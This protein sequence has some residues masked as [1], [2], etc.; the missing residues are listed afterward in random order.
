[1]AINCPHCKAPIDLANVSMDEV[2][3]PACGSNFRVTTGLTTASMPRD[4]EKSIGR[5]QLL[6]PLGM[7]AFGTV[8]KARDPELDR[9]VA[10]KVPR[11]GNVGSQGD[12]ERFLREARSVAQLRHPGIVSVHEVGQT[13]SVPFLVSE[14]VQGIS[15]SDW[16]TAH[17][18]SYRQAAELVARLADALAYAHAHGVVHRDIKPSNILLETGERESSAT[19]VG[20]NNEVVDLPGIPRLADFGLAKREAGEVTMTVEGQIL[21]T[22]AYMSPEQARGE[23]HQVDGRSDIYSLGVVLYQLLAGELPFRGNV[24][25]LLHQVL[26]D[27]PRSPRRIDDHIPRDLETICLKAMA[28][29]PG[30]RYQTAAELAEDLRRYLDGRPIAARPVGSLERAVKW[31]RRRPA[32]AGLLAA[33]GL[34]ALALVGVAVS[35]AYST[36]LSRALMEARE[37]RAEAD[38]QRTLAQ[39]KQ[40]EAENERAVAVEQRA[41]AEQ[42]TREADKQR[43]EAEKQRALARRYLYFSRIHMA[44]RA[45]EENQIPAMLAALEEER[46]K[47]PGDV[48]LRGFEWYH[49]WGKRDASAFTYPRAKLLGFNKQ[50][51]C[52]ILPPG[53]PS[54]VDAITRKHVITLKDVRSGF[55]EAVLSPDAAL[56]ALASVDQ[57]DTR[58][59]TVSVVDTTTG[60]EI[61]AVPEKFP[62]IHNMAFAPDGKRLAFNFSSRPE[63]KIWDLSDNRE[64]LTIAEGRGELAFSPNG[65]R[66][67]V[68]R[69]IC[70]AITGERIFQLPPALPHSD[71]VA[72]SPDGKRL[73]TGHVDGNVRIWDAVTGKPLLT[74]AGH[75]DRVRAIA[76][77]SGGKRLVTGGFDMTVRTW[78]AETGQALALF[79][80]H[81]GL[82]WRVAFSPDGARVASGGADGVKVWDVAAVR[83]MTRTWKNP[84]AGNSATVCFSPDDKLLATTTGFVQVRDLTSGAVIFRSKFRGEA[85]TACFSPNG[86]MLAANDGN[87]LVVWSTTTWKELAVQEGDTLVGHVVFSPDSSRFGWAYHGGKDTAV[88]VSDARTGKEMLVCKGAPRWVQG[89][90]FSPDGKLLAAT[91]FGSDVCFWNAATGEYV[92]TLTGE[93]SSGRASMAFSPDGRHLARTANAVIE[94]WDL[95]AGR[96]PMRLQ[97]HTN[98][99]SSVA[100]SPDGMRLASG[101]QDRT[102]RIWDTV[103]GSQALV[104]RGHGGE[105]VSVVF[106]RDGR[107]LASVSKD[108][109]VKVWETDR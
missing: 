104:L 45:W 12:V 106:S 89:L 60:K 16:L 42:K 61:L 97:G 58:R 70:N 8:Y 10:L 23:S 26:H 68:D 37:Q 34:A 63:C 22:P 72:F 43:A 95:T 82:I 44:D 3:C 14:L 91:P 57:E 7:G 1:M 93:N 59:R 36:R 88:R 90:A 81:T 69:G 102:V 92:R 32:V 94:I 62:F 24:R 18:A 20:L 79:K 84:P 78:D 56:L 75:T 9:T 83:D 99:T 40:E 64:S 21:G 2:V 49:L 76:F 47:A 28:K 29:E 30:R 100:F 25:M 52:L 5:F 107:R 31:V 101:S 17:R 53:R 11:A 39:E 4:G 35:Q 27:E 87:R 103:T 96:R 71:A 67:S 19:W 80:G 15:L 13:D 77:D 48:D 51:Q 33:S 86:E 85:L 54:L 41:L 6:E 74:L 109:I 65:R 50:G 38:S 108:G 105:V 55:A 46:P 73:A 98:Y 66:L